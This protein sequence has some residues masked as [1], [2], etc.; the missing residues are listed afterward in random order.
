VRVQ[1]SGKSAL[2]ADGAVWVLFV[3]ESRAE[4]VPLFLCGPER[5]STRATMADPS[6]ATPGDALTAEALHVYWS[7]IN[8]I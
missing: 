8:S 5:S 4:N 2:A 6:E 7:S 1:A 3:C